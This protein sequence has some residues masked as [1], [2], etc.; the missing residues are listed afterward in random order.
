MKLLIPL[1]LL[2]LLGL[3]LLFLIYILKPNYQQK[4][5]SSTYIWKLSLK[6]KKK[7]VPVSRLRHLLILLCQVF[8]LCGAAFVLSNPVIVH[9]DG[10]VRKDFRHRRFGEY[11]CGVR[12]RNP[13][14]ARSRKSTKRRKR[15]V[16]QR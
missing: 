2:G 3:V 1:G 12:G 8:I 11:A 10:S 9:G 5:V 6:Y 16:F 7:R 14:P 13:L 15:S 4:A